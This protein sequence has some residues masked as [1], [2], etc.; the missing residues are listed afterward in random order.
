MLLVASCLLHDQRERGA[1]SPR[2]HRLTLL[3]IVCTEVVKFPFSV[4][5]SL[6]FQKY[7]V[8]RNQIIKLLLV[9]KRLTSWTRNA[10][11][12]NRSKQFFFHLNFLEVFISQSQEEENVTKKGSKG[13]GW[14]CEDNSLSVFLTVVSGAFPLM[15]K[16]RLAASPPVLCKL[17]WHEECLL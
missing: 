8:K 3:A 9:I 2:T 7:V 5:F 17:R 14:I 11:D 13:A 12:T 15:G 6:I 16:E 10:D 4:Q 1:R